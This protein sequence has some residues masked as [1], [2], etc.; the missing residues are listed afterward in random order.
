MCSLRL[1]FS[2]SWIFLRFPRPVVIHR[3]IFLNEV[4]KGEE[5]SLCEHGVC[6]CTQTAT[7]LVARDHA[8]QADRWMAMNL[9]IPEKNRIV[10]THGTLYRTDLVKIQVH[11]QQR[12]IFL[13]HRGQDIPS[14]KSQPISTEICERKHAT[15]YIHIITQ[16]APS[17]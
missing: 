3:G 4:E 1:R 6:R 2:P 15:R 8:T 7:V 13:H 17:I 16:Q 10:I 11:S 5:C 14:M 12:M 9:S